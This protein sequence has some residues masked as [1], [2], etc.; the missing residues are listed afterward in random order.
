MLK[1]NFPNP[2]N[3]RNV[4]AD[5]P[6][7]DQPVS[8]ASLSQKITDTFIHQRTPR[9]I[10]AASVA[11]IRKLRSLY[12]QHHNTQKKVSAATAAAVTPHAFA[13]SAFSQTLADLLPVG[14]RVSQLLWQDKVLT[15]EGYS[16]PR[17]EPEYKLQPALARLMQN[18]AENA[19]PLDG[20]GL[21]AAGS[22]T[23]LSGDVGSFI[24]TCRQLDVGA[25]YQTQLGSIFERNAALLM[26]DKL[27][28][29]SLAVQVAFLRGAIMADVR[30]A[31]LASVSGSAQA[32]GEPTAAAA[33]VP[34]QPGDAP[35]L[36]A[37]PGLMS[38]LGVRVHEALFVQLRGV[39]D[40]DDGIVV[41]LPGQP[42]PLRWFAS[43]LEWVKEMAASLKHKDQLAAFIQLIALKDRAAFFSTLQLRLKDDEPDLEVEGDA[44]HEAVFKR[45]V[46]EQIERVK[47]DARLLLVPTADADADASRERLEAWA[48]LGWG[49]ASLAG[50]FIPVVGA[51]LLAHLVT[52]VCKEVFEGGEDWADG[53]DHEAL[54]HVLNVAETVAAVAATTAAA[55]GA[56]AAASAFVRSAFVDGLEPVGVGPHTQRLWSADLTPYRTSANGATLEDDGLYHSG[57]R[58]LLRVDEHYYEI[59]QVE[60][61]GP[62]RLQHPLRNTAYG[63]VVERNGERFWRVR[64][65][66]PQ[67]W[68]DEAKLL[69]RLWPR[70]RPLDPLQARRVL[71]A[72][73]SDV[74]E[75]RGIAV[76]NRAMPANLRDTL[77][78]FEADERIERFF[79]KPPVGARFDDR[80]LLEW[81][82]QRPEFAEMEGE[83]LHDALEKNASR[84]RSALFRHLTEIEPSTDQAAQVTRR[85]FAGLPSDY[86]SELVRT[87]SASEREVIELRRRLPLSVAQRAR[88]L[89]QLARLNRAQQGLMLRNAYVDEAGELAF[90]L[91]AKVDHW[92]LNTRLELRENSSSGRLL[93]VLNSQSPEAT[94]QILVHRDGQFTLYD[95][96]GLELEAQPTEPDDFFQAVY[97]LLE[98]SQRERLDLGQVNPADA[99][100]QLVLSKLPRERQR[101]MS[102]LGQVESKGWFNPGQRL[103]DGR[104]GYALGGGI[105]SER[106]AFLQL[107]RRLAALYEDDS[108]RQIQEHIERVLDTED[109][110]EQLV[111]EEHNL[112]MLESRLSEWVTAASEAELAARRVVSQ[113]LRAAWRRQLDIDLEHQDFQGYILDLSGVQVTSLPEMSQELDFHFV[114]SMLMVNS[115]LQEVP[116]SFFSCFGALRR[117]NLS[118]NNLRALPMGIRQ[119]AQLQRLQLSYNRIRWNDVATGILGELHNL[120]ALDLSFNPLRTMVLRFTGVP[121]LRRLHLM[122][123]G[124]LEWPEGLQHCGQLRF[125][126][127]NSNLLT[128]IPDVIMQL[129]Y[130]FRASIQLE[131]NAIQRTRLELLYTRPVHLMH[132]PSAAADSAP[133]ARALWVTGEQAEARGA[134]WDRLFPAQAD[135][136][137]PDSILRILSELRES[138]D[139]HNR[140]YREVLTRQV[141]SVLDTMDA[142]AQLAQEL[143]LIA[144]EPVT[145]ADSVAERFA[146][147]QLRVLVANAE[148]TAPGERDELLK[149]GSGLFRLKTLEAF[150]HADIEQRLQI[151]P[152]LDQIEARLYYI[153]NLAAELQ[154]PGQPASMRFETISG[155]TAA[156]LTKARA[157]VSA[158]ETV[159]AKAGFISE[160]R[161]WSTWLQAQYPDEFAAVTNEL[162]SLGAQLYET[163]ESLSDRQYKEQW[164]A[165]A[166]DREARLSR[167]KILLT[168]QALET[169]QTSHPD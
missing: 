84:L 88:S 66:L 72:A 34:A 54:Q 25:R 37:Y 59:R 82:K 87:L 147:L 7:V 118:R 136:E 127:L 52:H 76:E 125:V 12:L 166:V 58:R 121:V 103:P 45:W 5:T 39:D 43:K 19:T 57:A 156:Q 35:V 126:N 13:D 157:Y 70:E 16:V 55:A 3:A 9:W 145:C 143:R 169:G 152:D 139:F 85:D 108:P 30:A 17:L 128:S 160:Q 14:H 47:A 32:N 159:E 56:G 167:L 83:R 163:R 138:A 64:G 101:L 67:A 49:L 18:F 115:P 86:V 99:L 11:D 40:Q 140:A 153:V 105:S 120:I 97:C 124:L 91:F 10:K 119:L 75:L 8:D 21:V 135:D 60:N 24:A 28:G 36:T 123:C 161:F 31:L 42:E 137:Q 80:V 29:F 154:L 129:P 69:D 68:N 48:S 113:R 94:Q 158:A 33:A 131:R 168:T 74:D 162:D 107:R 78:R 110:F 96:R 132:G 46:D 109:P 15:L 106:G 130:E 20:S 117:V 6:A 133:S 50:F 71:Q 146:D 134:R 149:L 165:L 92:P 63:P 151:T 79:G 148:R 95:H 112:Q 102:A 111:F 150:I 44:H 141:W 22:D 73:C 98:P 144:D 53:H 38:M 116:E 51:L 155:G 142:D 23:L 90:N 2:A 62:W 122:H 164:D 26:E 100:R 81:C 114:T 4:A 27:A 104:V 89:L 93:A 1:R 61:Q 77:R 41:Y 65:E